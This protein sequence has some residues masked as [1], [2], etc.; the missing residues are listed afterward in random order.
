MKI[1][2]KETRITDE[3]KNQAYKIS[4]QLSINKIF[5]GFFT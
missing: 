4:V 1:I 2:Q 3:N 5:E